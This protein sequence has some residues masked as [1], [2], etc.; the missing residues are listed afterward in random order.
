L[1]VDRQAVVGELDDAL[2]AL[3]RGVP[4]ELVALGDPVEVEIEQPRRLDRAG[5][6]D[7]I[8]SRRCRSA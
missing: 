2:D 8:K 6:A 1:L 3:P 5:A 7:L 4:R